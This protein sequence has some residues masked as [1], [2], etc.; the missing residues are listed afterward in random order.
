[1]I[2]LYTI[3]PLVFAVTSISACSSQTTPAQNNSLN[4]EQTT[5]SNQIAKPLNMASNDKSIAKSDIAL[6]KN[7]SQYF[8]QTE[9]SE[10]SQ[11][12]KHDSCD[13]TK[14]NQQNKKIAFQITMAILMQTVKIVLMN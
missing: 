14:F 12:F 9:I 8:T 11:A 4:H 13:M 1:M 10:L 5:E 6:E 2:N 7:D 3:I